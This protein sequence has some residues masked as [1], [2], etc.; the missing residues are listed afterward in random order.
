MHALIKSMVMDELAL[1]RF[2]FIGA[3]AGVGD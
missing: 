3:P 1:Y 2:N